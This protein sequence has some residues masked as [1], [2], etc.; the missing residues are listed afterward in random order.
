MIKIKYI[1]QGY[2]HWLKYLLDKSYREK[3]KQLFSE[4]LKICEKCEHFTSTRQCNLCGCFMDVKCKGNY[5][6]INGVSVFKG[7]ID[8]YACWLK[9]W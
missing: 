9:K 3:Q 1:L 2:W 8:F 4:R 6:I 5:D 7:T